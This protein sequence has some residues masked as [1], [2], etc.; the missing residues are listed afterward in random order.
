MAAIQKRAIPARVHG[1]E[2]S[3]IDKSAAQFIVAVLL[4]CLL[5]LLAWPWFSVYYSWVG[6]YRYDAISGLRFDVPCTCGDEQ[7]EAK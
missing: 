5:A 1:G 4:L 6:R 2:M 3:E 7:S